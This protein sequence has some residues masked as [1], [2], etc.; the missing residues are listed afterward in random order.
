M[1]QQSAIPERIPIK[2]IAHLIGTDIH[3]HNKGFSLPDFNV[4]LPNAALSRPNGLHFRSEQ[5][6]SRFIGFLDEI[7]VICLFILN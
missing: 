2:N 3:S 1:Q 7:V 4:G 5:F 6:Q